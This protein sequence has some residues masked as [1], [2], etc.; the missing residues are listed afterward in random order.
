MQHDRKP[1]RSDQERRECNRTLCCLAGISLSPSKRARFLRSLSSNP[2]VRIKTRHPSSRTSAGAGMFERSKIDNSSKSPVACELSST[3]AARCWVM[4]W[5]P[6]ARHPRGT[7]RRRRLRRVRRPR[8]AAGISHQD[9]DPFRAFR[10]GRQG[11]A[12]RP[13]DPRRRA[14]RSL[15]RLGCRSRCRPGSD[16]ARLPVLAKAYHPDRMQAIELPAEIVDYATAMA[17]RI[18]AAYSALMSCR[19]RSGRRAG[20]TQARRG[21][22]A[23]PP[24][25][26]IPLNFAKPAFTIPASVAVE[27]LD[28]ECLV[29]ETHWPEI[30]LGTGGGYVT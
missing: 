25:G 24:C 16:Q 30:F 14:I 21:P 12:A 10:R 23:N 2:S 29:Q 3:M 15:R 1:G 8:P 5:S 11:R 4:S 9:L 27:R 19:A 7:Q 20:R 13:A 18:N 6:I 22:A 17:K 26:P 28:K